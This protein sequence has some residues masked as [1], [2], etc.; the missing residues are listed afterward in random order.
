MKTIVVAS[1]NPVK[2]KAVKNAFS[3]M[4][5]DQVLEL[6]SVAVAS[7]VSDQPASDEEVLKGAENRA[8]NAKSKL[9]RADYWVGIEGGIEDTEFGMAAFAW[10]VIM[11]DKQIGRGRSGTFFLP[12]K[13]ARLVRQGKELGEA[14]D[15]VFKR[16]NSKLNDGAIGLLTG[17]VIDRTTLYEH[18]VIMA[19]V[20]FKNPELYKTQKTEKD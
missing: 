9:Q 19:L 8:R 1:K 5:P 16:S 15:I 17:N 7:G 10:I 4:F 18:G 12:E 2:L 11:S 3:R 13:V 20:G 14:N 6:E